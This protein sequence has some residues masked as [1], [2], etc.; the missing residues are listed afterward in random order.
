MQSIFLDIKKVADFR[1]KNANV[2]RTLE[3]SHVIYIFF[4]C[5]LGK[6]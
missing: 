3:V 5:S 2:S 4:G 6:V 1:L